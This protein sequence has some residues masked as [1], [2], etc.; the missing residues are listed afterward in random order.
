MLIVTL[1]QISFI[2]PNNLSH[3][4]SPFPG[5]TEVYFTQ[6]ELLNRVLFAFLLLGA[7]C[8]L[9]QFVASMFLANPSNGKHDS[10]ITMKNFHKGKL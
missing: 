2:N 10:A 8:A 3:N 6:E 7:V 9:I 4:N 5:S 1:T